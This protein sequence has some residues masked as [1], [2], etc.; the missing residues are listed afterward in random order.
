MIRRLIK[1]FTSVLSSSSNSNGVSVPSGG[2]LYSDV[3]TGTWEESTGMFLLTEV[4]SEGSC[5]LGTDGWVY[6]SETVTDTFVIYYEI[7]DGKSS[8]M[9][10]YDTS[11]TGANG[12]VVRIDYYL[13]R[14]DSTETPAGSWV[15]DSLPVIEPV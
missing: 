14:K 15:C 7:L 8:V 2:S 11:S 12:S 9:S 10:L 4:R 1:V 13:T 5:G 6:E 3:M